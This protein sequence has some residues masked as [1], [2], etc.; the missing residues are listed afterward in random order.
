MKL[1][2]WNANGIR[3]VVRKGTL[4]EFIKEE[5]P[6]VLCLQET[7]AERGQAV[8]DLPDYEEY[9]NSST[10]K[11]GYAGTAIFVKKNFK[12]HGVLI[13]LP[14]DICKKY[15]ISDDY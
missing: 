1:T 15:K 7:K 4:Q 6:D 9:W 11:K 12:M 10:R 13:G 5:K 2:S 3:A 14:A 8:I